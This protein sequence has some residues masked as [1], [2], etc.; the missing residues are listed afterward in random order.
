MQEYKNSFKNA[1]VTSFSS[2]ISKEWKELPP[3]ERAKWKDMAEQDKRRYDVEKSRYTGPWVVR[4]E[5]IR[6]VRKLND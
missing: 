4:F 5:S 1:N 2:Q 3:S 6:K